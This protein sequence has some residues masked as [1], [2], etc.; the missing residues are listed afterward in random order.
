MHQNLSSHIANLRFFTQPIFALLIVLTTTIYSSQAAAQGLDNAQG[1]VEV[2]EPASLGGYPAKGEKTKGKSNEKVGRKSAE[3]YM[4][5]KDT[6]VPEKALEAANAH[7]LALHF[8][9]FLSDSAYKW[10][11]QDAQSNSGRWNL[12]VTYR[13][14][15]WVNSMDLGVR[16]DLS[17]YNLIDGT[18]TKLSFLPVIMF[19]DASSKFPLYF[20]AGAG[21][22]VFMKQLSNESPLSLDYQIF[23][24]VR[25]FDVIKNTGFFV[26]G[27]LKNHFLMLSDGQFNGTYFAVGSV[28][29]F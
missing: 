13:V 6:S 17:S 1:A 27:G 4:L 8:G 12:G 5:P 25:F 18:A 29:S 9:Y 10:G 14:G 2:S 22:G 23:G 26:E 21:L 7:Y 15:E 3:K 20:G 19:P 28:F 24:G 16:V 11:A